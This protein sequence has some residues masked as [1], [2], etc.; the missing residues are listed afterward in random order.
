MIAEGKLNL[1]ALNTKNFEVEELKIKQQALMGASVRSSQQAAPRSGTR[2]EKS[3]GGGGGVRRRNQDGKRNKYSGKSS[4]GPEIGTGI[5]IRTSTPFNG[6]RPVSRM[7]KIS[8][9]RP[10]SKK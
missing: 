6:S 8:V 4:R 2:K 5:Q 9:S 10:G 1:N 3:S 7:H